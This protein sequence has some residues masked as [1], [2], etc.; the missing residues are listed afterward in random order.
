MA[1]T[2]ITEIRQFF[3]DEVKDKKELGSKA[4]F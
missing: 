2:G 3:K 4:A 1:I